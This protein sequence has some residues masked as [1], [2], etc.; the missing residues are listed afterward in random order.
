MKDLQMWLYE[1]KQFENS[2]E[3][4]GFIY[5]IENLKN[6]RK[7]I[8]R[9]Y[10]TKASYK[11]TKGKRKKV[12]KE[13]D[14]A[15]YYGSSPSLQADVELYGKENFKRTILRLCKSRGECNYFET[16]EIFDRDAVLDGTYYNQWVSAKI[17]ASHVKSLHFNNQEIS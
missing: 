10:L 16:K 9:K 17:Q 1:D 13:S 6:G 14:W 8:G 4:Y 15:D 7:Y 11:T 3:W 2:D 12:R 5:L